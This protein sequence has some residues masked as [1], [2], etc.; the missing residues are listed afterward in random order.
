MLISETARRAGVGVETIR[1]YER[2][3]LIGRPL[4]PTAS[5]YRQYSAETVH[6][7]RFIKCAQQLGFSLA[8]VRELQALE[9]ASGAQCID[10]RERARLKLA[11]VMARI[12]NLT[13]IK[14]VL[15]QLIDACPGQ[16][17]ARKC[18]I[19]NEIKRGDLKFAAIAEGGRNDQHQTSD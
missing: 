8:E 2:K 10:V 5:G 9:S 18:S 3:G 7:I 13:R 6:H 17:S 14:S 1:F 11:D 12:E 4:R 19:L 16:G 15:E